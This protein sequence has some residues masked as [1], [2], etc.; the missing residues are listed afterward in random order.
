M[1]ANSQ[2]WSDPSRARPLV[3]SYE[4]KQNELG[5]GFQSNDP[6]QR[7]KSRC[8]FGFSDKYAIKGGSGDLRT[9]QV[10]LLMPSRAKIGRCGC[11]PRT[12]SSRARWTSCRRSSWSWTSPR[13][14]RH[15]AAPD[16]GRADRGTVRSRAG[17]CLGAPQDTH[18]NHPEPHPVAAHRG[19]L[20]VVVRYRV[21][22]AW[23]LGHGSTHCRWRG[24]NSTR[25]RPR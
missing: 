9:S 12:R 16:P 5:I 25:Q 8:R 22:P 10:W 1:T 23:P 13:P 18:R 17:R 7:N 3:H 11:G 2:H 21:A 14:R 4:E 19:D 6:Q 20:P 24:H 15:P